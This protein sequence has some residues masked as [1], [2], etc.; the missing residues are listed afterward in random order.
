M[1]NFFQV[2]RLVGIF[3]GQMD[4]TFVIFNHIQ[5]FT[6]TQRIIIVLLEN[7]ILALTERMKKPIYFKLDLLLDWMR[8][9][10][11]L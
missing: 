4:E 5:L 8:Q 6:H 9:K 7:F 10:I 3:N 1:F 2:A 11:K